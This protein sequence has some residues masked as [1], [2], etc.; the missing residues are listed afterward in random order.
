[1]VVESISK[2][3]LEFV[4]PNWMSF[5]VFIRLLF[6]EI[7]SGV[8]PPGFVL[9]GFIWVGCESDRL[10]LHGVPLCVWDWRN[11][12]T[13]VFN[14]SGPTWNKPY[15][16]ISG[17]RGLAG[18]NLLRRGHTQKWSVKGCWCDVMCHVDDNLENSHLV[19]C[20]KA[21]DPVCSIAG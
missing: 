19:P 14:K 8:S 17:Q 16:N 20:D 11:P 13:A 1:M 2:I 6:N 18:Q 7:L 12:G 15:T 21:N 10:K 3:V 9:G 5:Y 4:I